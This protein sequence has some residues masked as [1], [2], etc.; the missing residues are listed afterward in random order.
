MMTALNASNL[1]IGDKK[2][3]GVGKV[4]SDPL[5]AVHIF[6]TFFPAEVVRD[7]RKLEICC[8]QS[9]KPSGAAASLNPVFLSS[10]H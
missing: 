10:L 8:V 3:T 6:P 7:N 5:L 4:S 2:R 9:P 1:V